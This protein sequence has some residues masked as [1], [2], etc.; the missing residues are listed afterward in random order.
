M[1]RVLVGVVLGLALAA[2]GIT[3][4]VLGSD[5]DRREPAD[6]P[7]DPIA[8]AAL[9]LPE[10]APEASGPVDEFLSGD[11]IVV[12]R[13]LQIVAPLGALSGVD[14]AARHDSCSQVAA[15]LNREVDSDQLL[16][17]AGAVPDDLLAELILSART[18]VGQALAVCI[19]NVDGADLDLDLD[20]LLLSVEATQVL[21]ERRLEQL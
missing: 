15:Q 13:F 3:G 17:A 20:D 2:V 11:G 4:F 5:G 6:E 9:T 7:A 8:A 16:R 19:G 12:A 10:P 1:K 18:A 14:A 21:I